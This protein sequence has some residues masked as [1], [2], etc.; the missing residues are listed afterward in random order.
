MQTTRVWDLPTRFFHWLLVIAVVGLVVT[1]Q[2]GGIWMDW[3]FRLG[4]CVLTLLLFRF[5]WG[6][7][8]GYWSRFSH[9]VYS[10]STIWRYVRGHSSPA[11]CTGHNPLGFLSVFGMLGFLLL[12]VASGL[13]SDYEI[14]TSGP[15]SKF[16][17]SEWVSRLSD[18]HTDIGKFVVLAL[19]VL[20]IAAIAFYRISK[21]DD[22][23]RPMLFGDKLT[24]AMQPNARD[25]LGS[26][27][28]ALLVLGVCALPVFATLKWT[29]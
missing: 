20:H 17:N 22:L 7:I 18:H 8:G 12:Q 14:A 11:R 25:D 19:I 29:A 28:L 9:F 10:P 16:A 23:V 2:V 21:G 13:F 27:L 24:T 26:R 6:F 4:Y 1:G 3:H 15:L 5:D